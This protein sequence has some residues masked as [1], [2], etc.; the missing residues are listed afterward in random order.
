MG[1][2]GAADL[3][4]GERTIKVTEYDNGGFEVRGDVYLPSS[5]V[6]LT[7]TAF[8]W[9][10]KTLDEITMDSLRIFTVV[11]PR[12]E[13]VV[14]GLGRSPDRLLAPDVVQLLLDEGIAVEQMAT[15]RAIHTFN[16]LTDEDRPVGAAFLTLEPRDL[17]EEL[18]GAPDLA[19]DVVA[20]PPPPR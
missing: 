16:V 12:P 18:G 2:M 6:L 4:S 13:I 7:R 5:I 9:R 11:H 14:F 17:D 1:F 20:S 3:G 10:P 8:L 19:P 15:P